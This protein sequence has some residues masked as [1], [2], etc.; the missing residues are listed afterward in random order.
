MG[1]RGDHITIDRTLFR[2]YLYPGGYAVYPT[3]EFIDKFANET[4]SPDEQKIKEEN[5]K[6]GVSGVKVSCFINLLI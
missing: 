5:L 1:F 2:E 4:L 3:Q 6:A